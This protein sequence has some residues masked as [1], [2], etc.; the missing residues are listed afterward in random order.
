LLDPTAPDKALE[1]AAEA[2]APLEPPLGPDSLNWSD[3]QQISTQDL[4]EIPAHEENLGPAETAEVLNRWRGW[5]LEE[6]ADRLGI[7]PKAAAAVLR[8]EMNRSQV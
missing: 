7:T 4:D 1:A 6:I 2:L 8:R 3:I 5:E